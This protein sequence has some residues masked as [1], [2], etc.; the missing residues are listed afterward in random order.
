MPR[1]VG[2]QNAHASPAKSIAF[3]RKAQRPDGGLFEYT[4]LSA[5][6]G[7]VT[8]ICPKCGRLMHQRVNVLRLAAFEAQAQRSDR[9]T[10]N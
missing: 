10:S 1:S 9:D 5:T 2:R 6:T 3:L 4:P 8:A 7:K